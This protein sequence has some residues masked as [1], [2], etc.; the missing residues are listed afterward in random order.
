MGAVGAI[1]PTNFQKDAFGTHEI[2]NF[3]NIGSSFLIDWH[4]WNFLATIEWH[5]RSQNPNAPS[6]KEKVRRDKVDESRKFLPKS[7]PFWKNGGNWPFDS[8]YKDTLLPFLSKNIGNSL[9]QVT[10][11]T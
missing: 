1:A 5:L 7:R 9:Y 4:P 3:M 8:T 2:S 10:F 6:E 11:S